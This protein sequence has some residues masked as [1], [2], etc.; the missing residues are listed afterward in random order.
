MILK[1]EVKIIKEYSF[2]FIFSNV[3]WYFLNYETWPDF[4]SDSK[5]DQDCDACSMYMCVTVHP[6]CGLRYISAASQVS[7]VLFGPHR[8]HP[9][10]ISDELYGPNGQC[11]SCL[12]EKKFRWRWG[13]RQGESVVK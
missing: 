5:D 9:Q 13:A 8:E 10:Q 4:E 6:M 7:D 2:V 1:V 12:G 11:P 3:Q